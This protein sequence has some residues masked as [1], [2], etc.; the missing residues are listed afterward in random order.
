MTTYKVTYTKHIG[1]NGTVLVKASSP[2]QAVKNAKFLVATGSDFRDAVETDE[3]YTKPRNQGFQ[4][5]H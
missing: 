5:R 4:G 3:K 1:G 2:E